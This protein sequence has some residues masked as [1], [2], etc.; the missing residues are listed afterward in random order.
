[1]QQQKNQKKNKK[2]R[3]RDPDVGHLRSENSFSNLL[4]SN[5]RNWQT[6]MWNGV[7][8]TN[9]RIWRRSAHRMWRNQFLTVVLFL[10]AVSQRPHP[11]HLAFSRKIGSNKVFWEICMCN[12][13]S[14]SRICPRLVRAVKK[15]NLYAFFELRVFFAQSKKKWQFWIWA[16]RPNQRW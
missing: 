16:P 11:H 3:V 15:T 2:N 14:W 7:S 10:D 6:C 13:P 9:A 12:Q 1:M 4:G 5:K 8:S